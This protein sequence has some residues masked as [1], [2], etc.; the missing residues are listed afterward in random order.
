MDALGRKEVSSSTVISLMKARLSVQGP[1]VGVM[2]TVGVGTDVNKAG[3]GVVLGNG[4][5]DGAAVGGR[6]GVGVV[7]GAQA[8]REKMLVSRIR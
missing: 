8:N 5:A 2:V 6:N 3:M 7:R 1:D 4:K